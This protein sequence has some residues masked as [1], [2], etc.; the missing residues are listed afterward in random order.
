MS[1][2]TDYDTINP[3]LGHVHVRQAKDIRCGLRHKGKRGDEMEGM[4]DKQFDSYKAQ[5][6]DNVDDALEE[7][8][9]GKEPKKLERLRNR[10]ESELR[11]P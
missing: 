2:Y 11:Q 7:I 9:E 10:L 6:L 5:L 1:T 3:S 8:R 4:T